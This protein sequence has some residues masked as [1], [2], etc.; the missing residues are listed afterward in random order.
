MIDVFKLLKNTQVEGPGKRFCIWVQG[1]KKHCPN[2][3]AKDTWE[4][5][6][7]TKY[8]VDDLFNQ[9][10]EV[11]DIEGITF[12]GGE[13]FEQAD[14]LAELSIKIKGLGLSVLCFTGY[15]L[16]ELQSKNDDGVNL[17]LSSIDLL[18]DGGFEQDKFDLSRPWVGSSNQRYIFLTDFYNQEIISRYKNKIE[19]RI[20][21]DGKLEING[22]G[23]FDQIRRNFCLQLGKNNVK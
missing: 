23:D 14:E 16:E 13:P 8:S 10:K 22:M 19:A 2:C 7:G 4:F 17:F 11:Q 21:E 12:L 20:G 9:I 6:I 5:G 18:I 15:T 1:C 3:W